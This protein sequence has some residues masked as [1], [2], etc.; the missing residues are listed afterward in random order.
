M[1]R[2]I[3]AG[4]PLVASIAAGPRELDGFLFPGG[5]SGHLVVVVGFDGSGNPIVNDPAAWSDA[6]VCRVYGRGQF[7]RAWLRGSGGV[8]YV[9]HPPD[10]PLP[11]LVP[12]TPPNW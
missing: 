7:E 10:V 11:P 9:V 2:F 4:I 3:M 8:V 12:G 1:T 6:S 5:T